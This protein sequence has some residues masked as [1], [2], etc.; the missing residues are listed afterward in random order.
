[1]ELCGYRI[2]YGVSFIVKE[3]LVR[4]NGVYIGYDYLEKPYS[5]K[6]NNDLT[7]EKIA[8]VILA[9]IIRNLSK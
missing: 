6:T 8:L 1:M 7:R 3:I 2:V 9:D 4:E 5:V